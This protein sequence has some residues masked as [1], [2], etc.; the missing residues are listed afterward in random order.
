MFNIYTYSLH[1]TIRLKP[2]GCG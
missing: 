1:I 2:F